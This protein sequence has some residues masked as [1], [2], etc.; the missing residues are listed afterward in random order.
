[1]KPSHRWVYGEFGISEG[2]LTRRGKK[3]QQ[4][5][6]KQYMR[7]TVYGEVAQTR[8]CH[9]RVGLGR[10]AQAASLVLKVVTEPEYP[11]DNLRELM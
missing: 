5:Q 4:Q 3:Q 9:Q 10:E 6:K 7:L 8:I 1:M 2:S 11:E